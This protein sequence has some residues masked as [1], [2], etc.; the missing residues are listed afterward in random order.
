V[1]WEAL[2][3]FL[4]PDALAQQQLG[5]QAGFAG[6]PHMPIPAG[7][8]APTGTSTSAPYMAGVSAPAGTPAATAV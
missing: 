6:M 3:E 1:A 7:M 5:L 8:T 4:G 2:F